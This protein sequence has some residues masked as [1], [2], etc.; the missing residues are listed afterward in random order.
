MPEPLDLSPVI[1]ALRNWEGFESF[2]SPGTEYLEV[3]RNYKVKASQAMQ[4]LF[5]EQALRDEIARKDEPR[6]R[7]RLREFV[8]EKG[9]ANMMGWMDV[10]EALKP[11]LYATD[12]PDRLFAFFEAVVE[13]YRPD[14]DIA[15]VADRI[16]HA[17]LGKRAAGRKGHT[18]V[19]VS[20]LAMMLAPDRFI[21]VKPSA[22]N[23]FFKR[24]G[25]GYRRPKPFSGKAYAEY[26]ARCREIVAELGRLGYPPKDMIDL[27][28]AMWI[29]SGEGDEVPVY[30]RMQEAVEALTQT[31]PDGVTCAEIR[32]YLDEKHPR[33]D[34]RA[35]S[36]GMVIPADYALWEDT[37]EAVNPATAG[38]SSY[39]KFLVCLNR[40][41]NQRFRLAREDEN[42]RPISPK[43][44]G[45]L[46][47]YFGD[48]QFW[49]PAEVIANY[50][51][52]L[53]T[54]PFVILSGISGT[55]KTKI[56]QLFAAYMTQEAS[57]SRAV[58]LSVRPDWT[59]GRGLLGYYNPITEQYV[60][61]E[62][63][64]LMLRATQDPENP[65]FVILDE[66]NLARVEHY[67]S[68]FLSCLE[69]R[70]PDGNGG[71][72]Q[73]PV[74]LHHQ[75][76]PLAVNDDGGRTLLIPPR[77]EIPMNLFITGTVNVD[78]TTYMFSP[79]VL[80]RANTIEFNIVDL[81]RYGNLEAGDAPSSRYRLARMPALG[82]A[83]QASKEAYD[84]LPD[85]D[86]A[87]LALLNRLL[88]PAQL[89]FGYRVAN[90]IALYLHHAE[91]W[92]GEEARTTAMDLQLLQK[93]L[94]KFHGSRSK[95]EKTLMALLHF[96]L[97]EAET[98]LNAG[99]AW[100]RQ[101]WPELRLSDDQQLELPGG[102]FRFPRTA[103]KVYRMLHT[104]QDQGYASF[105][106]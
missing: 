45:D 69:S 57:S 105:I 68:D 38:D 82:R 7:S 96:C 47:A 80:D 21:F 95:L 86:K 65:Y 79:K 17:L 62:L 30:E 13:L 43:E 103:G 64:K 28:T 99:A 98:N 75:P 70:R 6:L 92:V 104:L 91:L 19:C 12:E 85:D 8:R 59:D 74:V 16:A 42:E 76:E 5:A 32:T 40:T 102:S 93:V 60:P 31:R 37:L 20:Y 94:P 23:N 87:T 39:P 78:E 3:E 46:E 61:T 84:Q 66:M 55:G 18:W 51:I 25:S 54:K 1:E 4:A 90:E 24:I 89:H 106:A 35:W 56:A 11:L 77:L 34:G 36:T 9:Y 29:L 72:L 2:D 101:V 67:F 100:T 88:A 83:P 41:G 15:Q 52:S 71:V 44:A 58:F 26:V 97:E 33:P 10:R 53:M 50:A 14:A 49:L 22:S 27:Q 73:E 81:E 48:R 63:L